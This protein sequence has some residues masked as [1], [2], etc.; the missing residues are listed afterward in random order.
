MTTTEQKVSQWRF[1]S[2]DV[3]GNEDEGYEVNDVFR[4]SSVFDIP[5]DATDEQILEIIEAKKYVEIDN[6][7]MADDIIYFQSSN[8]GK[9]LGEIR[10]ELDE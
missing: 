1:Y 8:T 3:W 5:D 7:V 10:K 4:T 2:Y 9:P 6:N